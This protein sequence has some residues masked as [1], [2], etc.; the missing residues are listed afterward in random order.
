MIR[1]LTLATLFPDITRPTFGIFVEQQT[2]HLAARDDVELEVVAPIGVAPWPLNFHY[3]YRRFENVPEHETW[4]DLI[5]H[6]PRFPHIPV[7]GGRY[8]PAFMAKALLPLLRSIRERFPFDIIDAQFFYPDGPAAMH[9]AEALGVPFSVKARGADIHYWSRQPDCREQILDMANRAAGMLAVS[10]AMKRDMVAL[11]MAEDKITV[12]YTGIDKDRFEPV[13]REVAKKALGIHGD[14]IATVGGLIDRKGQ[15][16]V[17]EALQHVPD[18]TLWCI[19]EGPDRDL[20]ERKIAEL[21]QKDRIKL[22]GNLPHDDVAEVLGA[23]D[24]MVLPSASEGLA[25]AWVEALASGT[26]IVISNAG[27]ADE[28]I[29][30]PEAGAIVEREP[31]AI[32]AAVRKILADPPDRQAVRNTVDKFSWERNSETLFAHLSGLI[33]G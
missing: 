21:G 32:A 29:D 4:K 16:L 8:D 2:L 24:V 3:R 7:V 26:P 5:V 18:A 15:G 19:G 6:R 10:E 13:D 28:L 30:R 9:L 22:R 11:G 20:L 14:F 17:I 12:H 23:A 25:N 31:Q 33:E 27:G 1:V